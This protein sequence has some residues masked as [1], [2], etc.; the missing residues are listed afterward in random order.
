MDSSHGGAAGSRMATIH[1]L[2]SQRVHG[3]EHS[4]YMGNNVHAQNVKGT[5]VM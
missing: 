2:T 5:R 3:S 4:C 1:Q